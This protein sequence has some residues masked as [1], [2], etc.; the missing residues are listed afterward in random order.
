MINNYFTYYSQKY[1]SKWLVFA[2]DL[3][4]IMVSFFMAYFIRFN[5]TLNFD[6]NQFL[7]QIPFLL[8]VSTISFLTIGSF[9]SI[10]RHTG[11]TDIIN[12][13]KSV[14]LIT[15]ISVLFVF[16]NRLTSMVPGFT[17]PLSIMV[18]HAVFSFVFLSLSRLLFKMAYN[19]VKCKYV[20]SKNILIY[21]AG[22]TGMVTYNALIN[23]VKERFNVV[24]FIDD[25]FSKNGKAINGISIL[26]KSKI[27]Q[28]YID[29]HRIDE[30]I[31]TSEN[32]VKDRLLSL[33]GL[34]VKINKVP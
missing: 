31:V 8:V 20:A 14:T 26:H 16:I 17:I 30:I 25:N 34:T 19:H 11:F 7:L 9:K 4:I 15:V 3:S 10:I 5:F 27:N 32:I 12:L 22:D 23:N 33:V 24:G 18:M 21:G 2:I 6:L 28:N 13:L 1:A 29:A